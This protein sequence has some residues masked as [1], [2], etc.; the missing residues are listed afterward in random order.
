[1]N[2]G[3]EAGSAENEGYCHRRCV[4]TRK[5]AFC[6]EAGSKR[7]KSSMKDDQQAKK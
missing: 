2:D 1:M 7:G 5:N 3:K 4:S 6:Q